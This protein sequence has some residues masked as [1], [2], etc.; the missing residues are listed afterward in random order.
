[1]EGLLNYF[2]PPTAE[3]KRNAL[4]MG[5]LQAGLGI[6]MGAQPERGYKPPLGPAI[7]M[8][9]SMGLN[10]YN[11]SLQQSQKDRAM[12]LM[13]AQNLAKQQSIADLA[14]QYPQY[15][16]FLNAGLVQPVFERAFPKNE[17]YTLGPGQS[18][19][20]GGQRVASEPKE[21]EA[22]KTRTVRIGGEDI[23]QEFNPKTMQ[24]TEVGRGPAWNP[25]PST[26]VRIENYPNPIPV[27]GPD[28]KPRMVQFGNQGAM[29]ET[30][31]TPVPSADERRATRDEQKELARAQGYAQRADLVIGKVDEAL[32]NVGP[33]TVG[34]PGAV[35]GKVPGTRAYDLDKTIDT[36]KA[37]IGFQELQE[38]RNASPTGGALGQ[39]A[40]KELEYL[41]AAIS[42][43]DKGQSEV[44]IRTNLNAVKTHFN[45][46]KRTL[47]ASESTEPPQ[48]I[49]RYD[50]QGR[51]LP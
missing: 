31:Y 2:G 9:G 44:Q 5:L 41:Q 51:R 15:A 26:S 28:G 18:R 24:W 37:N 17:G 16:G 10:A 45:N 33:L 25:N 11:Q 49:I 1:M 42:N 7:G 38:M 47:K 35:A 19:Y 6:L 20:E 43:L 27:M 14:K 29:V 12:Q 34:I 48:K 36:I 21:A 4:N 50:S 23:T 46:W 39:V 40:V 32:K 3:D 22:P 8:G 13:Q 30:P